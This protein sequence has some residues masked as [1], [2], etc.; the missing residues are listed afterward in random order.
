M[1]P[2]NVRATAADAAA[3]LPVT[4]DECDL[5][6]G[7]FAIRDHVAVAVSG[8]S[9]SVALM[10]LARAWSQRHGRP[11]LTVLTVDHGLREGSAAEAA[12]V[13]VWAEC[14]GVPHRTLVW[15]GPKPRTGVQAAARHARYHLMTRW[16]RANGGDA[17]VLA[18]TLE[19]Q[20]ETVV[21]RLARGSG[22]DGLSAMA[23]ESRLDGVTLLRP[24]LAVRKARLQATLEALGQPW[25]E[26]PS[27]RDQR[28]E[29]VRVR[30]ALAV[31]EDLGV[32]AE[33]IGRSAARLGEAR[34][35]LDGAVDQVVA[36][37]VTC[38]DA[39]VVSV[40]LDQL[41]ATGS[42]IATRLLARSVQAVGGQPRPPGHE[43]LARL[44]RQLRHDEGSSWTL[45]GCAIRRRRRQVLICR[46]TG[47]RGPDPLALGDDA[48]VVWDGR[49]R[50]HMP[51]DERPSG[52]VIR[53]LDAEGWQQVVATGRR[54]RALPA[55]IGRSLPSVWNRDRLVG[56]PHLQR[57]WDEPVAVE[58]IGR[59]L[60]AG[61]RWQRLID[62]G[63][64]VD[65]PARP[66][67]A[68]TIE[69]E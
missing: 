7:S 54:H 55:Y 11:R 21:M 23:A 10:V 17:V 22:V 40:D 60:L 61:A 2:R 15:R 3:G 46:E 33:A 38:F 29:R 8:G 42:E 16:C 66:I 50:V 12:R 43:A 51:R 58:F 59:D 65:L 24:F 28:Y 48:T 64:T 68:A 35:A 20:A 32:S 31:L 27:N 26:D 9:D 4:V 49:F 19:D 41:T 53:A 47:R 14:C 5:L 30:R 63:V 25:I 45:G 44:D 37:A 62:A 52:L 36:G 1:P 39:G 69:N 13:A 57:S 6:L 56:V 18:H 34:T 67:I